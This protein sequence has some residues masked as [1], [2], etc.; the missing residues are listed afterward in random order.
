MDS[1]L[2]SIDKISTHAQLIEVYVDT[3]LVFC[4]FTF[5]HRYRLLQGF[6]ASAAALM[7][8]YR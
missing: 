6:L 3:P 5:I 2:V 7:R 4:E 1:D 8:P